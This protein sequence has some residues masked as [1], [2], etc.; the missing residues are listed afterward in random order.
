MKAEGL[1]WI[2]SRMKGDGL[3]WLLPW[4]EM[5]RFDLASTLG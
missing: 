3:V 1:V 5:R 4:D 2:C